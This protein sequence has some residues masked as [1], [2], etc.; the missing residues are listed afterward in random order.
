MCSFGITLWEPGLKTIYL[1]RARSQFAFRLLLLLSD[2][3]LVLC[4][5]ALV[6]I[7]G[8]DENSVKDFEE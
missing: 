6:K 4:I 7:Y 3:S 5:R 1:N 8:G 2:I